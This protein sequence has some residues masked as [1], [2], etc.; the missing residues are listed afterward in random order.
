MKQ[1]KVPVTERALYQRINRRLAHDRKRL[2]ASRSSS[3]ETTVGRYYVLD[4]D[5]HAIIATHVDLEEIAQEVGA[6]AE[7]ERLEA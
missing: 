5:I 1:D 6:L 7:W 4:K 2:C 3:V